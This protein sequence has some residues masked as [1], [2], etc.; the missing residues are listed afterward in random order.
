MPPI[1][2][3]P[4]LSELVPEGSIRVPVKWVFFVVSIILSLGVGYGGYRAA[5]NNTTSQ[6]EEI[7]A[8]NKLLHQDFDKLNYTIGRLEQHLDDLGDKID[9]K[10]R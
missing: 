7:K 5:F 2:P 3:S 1:L 9:R 4:D 6:V 8:D 10:V